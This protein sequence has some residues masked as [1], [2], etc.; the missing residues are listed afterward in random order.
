MQQSTLTLDFLCSDIVV[1]KDVS[2]KNA[3]IKQLR[4]DI[5]AGLKPVYNIFD[6]DFFEIVSQSY[7]DCLQPYMKLYGLSEQMQSKEAVKYSAAFT[8]YAEEISKSIATWITARKAFVTANQ[9]EFP[10]SAI[11]ILTH[12][13]DR[14]YWILQH[15]LFNNA[16]YGLALVTPT[17]IICKAFLNC[18]GTDLLRYSDWIME[19]YCWLDPFVYAM[20]RDAGSSH[21]GFDDISHMLKSWLEHQECQISSKVLLNQASIFTKPGHFYNIELTAIDFVLHSQA[22]HSWYCTNAFG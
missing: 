19:V 2:D 20:F 16:Q 10:D 17:P 3:Y 6:T 13:S 22:P 9:D 12:L 11:S 5:Y 4:K 7:I 21:G 15:N 1:A 18:I 8:A 14:L